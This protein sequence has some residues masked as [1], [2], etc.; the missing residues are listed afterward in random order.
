MPIKA[1]PANADRSLV[2]GFQDSVNGPGDGRISADDVKSTIAPRITDA[3]RLTKAEKATVAWAKEEFR[4]TEPGRKALD[5]A[6]ADAR[7][8]KS[9][10]VSGTV[11]VRLGGEL[12]RAQLD[13]KAAE[14]FLAHCH[15]IQASARNEAIFAHPD[16]GNG[17]TH[18]YA[19]EGKK[20]EQFI[21]FLAHTSG[22]ADALRKVTAE[23]HAVYSVYESDDESHYG[24]IL[25]DKRTGETQTFESFNIVD[26]PYDRAQYEAIFGVMRGADGKPVSDEVFE[27]KAYDL[28]MDDE[29]SGRHVALPHFGNAQVKR[30]EGPLQDASRAL[31]ET[32]KKNPTDRLVSWDYGAMARTGDLA[33]QVADLVEAAQGSDWRDSERPGFK[34]KEPVRDFDDAAR[35]AVIATFKAGGG[36]VTTAKVNAFLEGIG[37]PADFKYLSVELPMKQTDDNN[38]TKNFTV[39]AHI[40]VNAKDGDFF[41]VYDRARTPRDS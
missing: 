3:G 41:T 35:E 12:P 40:V 22:D 18:V 31:S 11:S 32:M 27:E 4:M 38:R 33:S 37:N 39:T 21:R 17:G 23:T 1:P 14:A 19:M 28:N 24:G 29:L 16:S 20:A 2:R 26:I 8:G 9:N 25:V 34:L 15:N 36:K 30:R 10:G 7:A 5:A 6:V 13:K